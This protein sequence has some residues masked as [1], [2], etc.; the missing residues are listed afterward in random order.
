MQGREDSAEMSQVEEGTRVKGDQLSLPRPLPGGP[1]PRSLLLR[2]KAKSLRTSMQ[3]EI[4][5][6]HDAGAPR[7]PGRCK[8]TLLR[9][10]RSVFMV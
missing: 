9:D 10:N 7:G 6:L 5:L 4:A 3:L 2:K 8:H 1:R